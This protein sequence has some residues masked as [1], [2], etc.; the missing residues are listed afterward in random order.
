ML[1]TEQSLVKHEGTHLTVRPLRCRC[2]QCEHCA[3]E[4]RRDL[5]W[6]ARNGR[7]TKFL[8]LTIRKGQFATPALQAA[9]MAKGWRMLRQYLCR[10]LDRKSIPFLAI[11]EKHK[12]GWP[13]LHLLLRTGWIDHRLIREWW[14]GRFNSPMI[15]I[16]EVESEVKAAVYVSKYVAKHPE[17]YEGAKRYWC[18]KDWDPPKGKE[19][20]NAIDESVWFEVLTSTPRA[21]MR[22]AWI[23]GASFGWEGNVLHIWGWSPDERNK[24]WPER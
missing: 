23:D 10:L 5:K 20:S 15:W 7:P 3:P 8:T 19:E 17:R 18:S 11:I 21:V 9:E 22:M 12:S 1:C 24:W 6:K 2:W 16:E 14:Q 13:H 4:R